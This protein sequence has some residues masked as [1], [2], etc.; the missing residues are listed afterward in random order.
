VTGEVVALATEAAPFVTAY[1]AAVKLGSAA[2]VIAPVAGAEP[3]AADAV[4]GGDAGED[5][6]SGG[7]VEVLVAVALVE[8]EG[9]DLKVGA[10]G[11][12]SALGLGCPALRCAR[13]RHG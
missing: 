11:P 9:C 13:W 8:D 4:G 1:G 7:D 5:G 10:G 12:Q 2:V 3:G 6:E